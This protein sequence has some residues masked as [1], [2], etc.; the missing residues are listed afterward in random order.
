MCRDILQIFP[1]HTLIIC[2]I[3]FSINTTTIAGV[4]PFLEIYMISVVGMCRVFPLGR[5]G[6]IPP[7]P[8]PPPYE[9]VLCK[10]V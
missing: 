4:M 6:S 8:P 1:I 5:G 9:Y 10:M 2:V 3:H 7:Q